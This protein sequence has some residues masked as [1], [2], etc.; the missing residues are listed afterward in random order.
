[1][2]NDLICFSH[3]RWNFVYQRPQHLMSRAVRQGRVFY[4][5]EP[6]YTE[7]PDQLRVDIDPVDQVI[8]V[9]PE[10]HRTASGSNDVR[11]DHF[12]LRMARLVDQLIL[13][14]QITNFV[15]WYYAPMALAFSGHLKPMAIIYDCMDEL[16]AFKFAPPEL[17]EYE[18]KLVSKA[19]VV[20]TG[21]HRLF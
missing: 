6:V 15:V 2:K 17:V 3:L 19:D 7:M 21:G 8:V 13:E 10:L 1:M 16:S 5:E 11:E 14:H 4:V 20:F 9:R 18:Q 12:E